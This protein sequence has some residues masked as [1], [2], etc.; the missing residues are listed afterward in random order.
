MKPGKGRGKG[1]GEGGGE[2]GGDGGPGFHSSQR[3]IFAPAVGPGP[4]RGKAG[5]CAWLF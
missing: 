1:R 4:S 5:G 3:A 2:G